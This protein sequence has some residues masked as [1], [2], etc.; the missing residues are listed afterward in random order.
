MTKRQRNCNFRCTK[1]YTIT[2]TQVMTWVKSLEN[3][4]PCYDDGI[5]VQTKTFR[6][7]CLLWLTALFKKHL[8]EKNRS[9]YSMIL[10]SLQEDKQKLANFVMLVLLDN[11][12]KPE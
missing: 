8:Y 9:K 12:F 6:L 11:G 4:K 1:V 7:D 3:T 2:D 5:N 10:N